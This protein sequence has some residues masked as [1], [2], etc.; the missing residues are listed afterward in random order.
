MRWLLWIWTSEIH[1]FTRLGD[2]ILRW[3]LCC[4]YIYHWAHI[5]LVSGV[6]TSRCCYHRLIDHI[7]FQ[8]QRFLCRVVQ[9]WNVTSRVI[10]QWRCKGVGLRHIDVGNVTRWLLSLFRRLLSGN[11]W[12]GHVGVVGRLVVLLLVSKG[13]LGSQ[14]FGWFRAGSR[15]SSHR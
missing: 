6:L 4:R 2:Q 3:L 8:E 1:C 5:W 12:L 14:S 10:H 9:L 7:A 15:K 11:D 13:V